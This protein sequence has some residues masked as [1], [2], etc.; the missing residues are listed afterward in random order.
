MR[1]LRWWLILFLPA[2]AQLFSVTALGQ[3]QLRGSFLL[4]EGWEYSH[5]SDCPPWP[6]PDD[7]MFCFVSE[8][9]VVIGRRSSWALGF[10]GDKLVALQGQSLTLRYDK[11]HIWVSI[12]GGRETQLNQHYTS[13]SFRDHLCNLEIANRISSNGRNMKRPQGVHPAAVPIVHEGILQWWDYCIADSSDRIRCT[14]W[15]ASGSVLDEGYFLPSEDNRKVPAA[16]LVIDPNKSAYEFILLRNGV[17]L[18]PQLGH[19]F[20]KQKLDATKQE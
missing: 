4:V 5:C 19:E 7:Y 14:I 18:I 6:T 8:R 1:S 20:Y 16:E 12:P 2:L 10:H 17:T 3:E 9:A 11:D 13:A 15:T